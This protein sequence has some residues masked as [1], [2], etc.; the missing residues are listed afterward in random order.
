MT[1][2]DKRVLFLQEFIQDVLGNKRKSYAEYGERYAETKDVMRKWWRTFKDEYFEDGVWFTGYPV[3][4]DWVD[5]ANRALNAVNVEISH[6]DENGV[7]IPYDGLKARRVWE[8]QTKGGGVKLLHSYEFSEEKKRFEDF[9][10]RLIASVK[11]SLEGVVPVSKMRVD[12]SNG[13]CLNVYTADKHVGADTKGGLFGNKYNKEEYLRRMAAIEPTIAYYTSIFGVFD[14]INVID[15]GDGA[16]GLDGQTARKGH[17][18]SQNM[19]NIEQYNVY[20]ESHKQLFDGIVAGNYTKDL[21]YIAVTND[22]HNGFFMHITARA[23]EE[24]LNAKYPFVTTRVDHSFMFH[25]H[26]G[27]H[28]FIF[29]HGKDDK[30]QKYGFPFRLDKRAED[31]INDYIMYNKL[32]EGVPPEQQKQVIHFI[33]GDLHQSG[34]EFGKRFRYKNIMSM[35]GASNYIQLNY[36]N[37]YKGF[38]FEIFFKDTPHMIGGKMFLHDK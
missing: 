38:E 32:D 5:L 24:I 19:D 9:G 37:G 34:E 22:N 8:G 10:D 7:P 17:A 23:V 30:V 29:C 35:Y 2:Q 6:H 25:E 26:Y 14:K 28:K 1:R 3:T 33:K 20:V 13:L 27:V 36:G 15:L 16:D 11:E 21:S 4:P 12:H 31:I 18:L